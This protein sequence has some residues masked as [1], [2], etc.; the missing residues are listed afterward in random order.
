MQSVLQHEV[1]IDN[2]GTW[3]Y[4]TRVAEYYYYTSETIH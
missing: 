1:T 3:I 4:V 2:S